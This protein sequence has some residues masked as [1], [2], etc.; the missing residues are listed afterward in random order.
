[1]KKMLIF[2]LFC[3]ILFSF[4]G[5]VFA[6]EKGSI[7]VGSIGVIFD[8]SQKQSNVTKKQN[9]ATVTL[10]KSIVTFY[11]SDYNDFLKVLM[12]QKINWESQGY[13]C[14]INNIR[15]S[16]GSAVMHCK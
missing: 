15:Y 9:I 1:M 13:K 4:V 5:S 12:Q 7:G 3:G 6:F 16:D 11:F 2:A 10:E 14:Y 8:E